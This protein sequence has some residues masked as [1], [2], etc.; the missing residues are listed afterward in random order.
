M[1]PLVVAVHAAGAAAF[2]GT[3][4]G[5]YPRLK[6]A[7]VTLAARHGRRVAFAGLLEDAADRGVLRRGPRGL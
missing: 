6:L 4:A 3:R 2:A 1:W 5:A 7:E